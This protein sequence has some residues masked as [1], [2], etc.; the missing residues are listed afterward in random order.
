M[1]KLPIVF[2]LLAMLTSCVST[3]KKGVGFWNADHKAARLAPAVDALGNFWY[4]NWTPDPDINDGAVKAEFVPMVWHGGH[5]TPETIAKLK[6]AGYKTL[7]GF[8]EPDGRTQANMTVAEAIDLWPILMKSGMRLGSPAPVGALPDGKDWLGDFMREAGKR[9]YRVDFICLHWYGDVTAP[10]A[11]ERLKA[12]LEAQW[13]LY[14]K[15]IWLT[16]FSGST[17]YWIKP[18]NPPLTREKNAAFIRKAIPMLESLPYLERYA[19]FE[20]AYTK[21]PWARVALVSP[22]TGRLT[23]AGKA[24]READR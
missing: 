16:E 24:W 11:V 1:N 13:K 9:R 12:F 5:A 21:P 14:K 17:G 15:P 20:L 6:K 4:Y 2:C 10:D 23:V 8:N 18:E 7:L 22:K 19:W 3:E